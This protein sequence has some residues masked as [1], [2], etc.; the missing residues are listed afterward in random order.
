MHLAHLARRALIGAALVTSVA[1]LGVSSQRA[2]ASGGNPAILEPAQ[3]ALFGAWTKPRDG[4]TVQQELAFSEQQL[5]RSF[6]LYH[7][8]YHVK[9]ALPTADMVSAAKSGH[10]ILMAF[11]PDP[12][13]S[14]P[15]WQEIWQGDQDATLIQ[16]ARELR[17]FGV[18]VMLNFDHEADANIGPNGTAADYVKAYQHVH[19]L[20]VAQGATNVIWVWDMRGSLFTST[21]AANAMYPGDRYV[22]WV[23]ADAYN[24]FPGKSGSNWRSFS[25]AFIAFHQ[26]A[27]QTHPGIPQMAEETG[28]QEDT[29]TPDA[30]RKAAWIRDMAATIK[31]WPE[32]KAVV[33][34][35]SNQIYPWWYDSS[36][37]S[38][39]AFRAVAQD[40]YFQTRAS[41]CSSGSTGGTGGG[42]GSSGGSTA[43]TAAP[44]A[45]TALAASN[46]QPDSFSLSWGA[47]S[48]N[49]GVTGY[50]VYI[51]GSKVS[52]TAGLTKSITGTSCPTG[53][54]AW[55]EAYDAAGNLSPRTGIDVNTPVVPATTAVGGLTATPKTGQVKISFTLSAPGT[56]SLVIV[57]SSGTTITH[58]LSG[59]LLSGGTHTY[60]WK[61]KDDRGQV[62]SPGTYG[63][64]VSSSGSGG[65][66]SVG[67]YFHL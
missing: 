54:S 17:D 34:F 60:Y 32:M 45:P 31:S 65:S 38:L 21:A 18:P 39:S 11:D 2:T 4:R 24:W 37:A 67:A 46:V 26:W 28:V 25:D 52:S 40:C 14:Q 64:V 58:K 55:V 3:G 23:A 63:A 48:D 61:L 49:V 5:G 36:S 53:C 51:N 9:Q 62:V 56:V 57:N 66:A 47:S 30:S 44:S 33:W 10:T 35:N 43:D 27:N 42:S 7:L 50:N 59:V 29:A 16:R 15:T 13:N 41:S 8:Y 1:A 12:V 19:D 20:F 22:D 6:D